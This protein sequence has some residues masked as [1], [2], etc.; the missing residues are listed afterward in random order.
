MGRAGG[1]LTATGWDE[2]CWTGPPISSAAQSM[3]S[4]VEGSTLDH[5]TRDRLRAVGTTLTV[6]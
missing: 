5:R 6:F 1:G 4:A 3:I 2:D